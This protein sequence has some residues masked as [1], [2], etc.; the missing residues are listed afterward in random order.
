M[1]KDLNLINL[2]TVM[3]HYQKKLPELIQY[4]SQHYK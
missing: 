1:R 4:L 2:S 3:Y